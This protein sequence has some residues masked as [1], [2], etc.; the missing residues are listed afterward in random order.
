MSGKIL[1]GGF[2]LILAHLF[3]S[4]QGHTLWQAMVGINTPQAPVSNPLSVPN[5]GVAL[6]ATG[7]VLGG[8]P[9]VIGAAGGVLQAVPPSRLGAS[10]P[11]IANPA[12]PNTAPLRINKSPTKPAWWPWWIPYWGP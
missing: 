10:D 11:R 9:G 1:I 5:I 2:A 8:F 7:G 6:P 12:N 3:A 4:K